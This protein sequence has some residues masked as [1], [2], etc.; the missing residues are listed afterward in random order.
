MEHPAIHYTT[1][2]VKFFLEPGC[3]I[4]VGFKKALLEGDH[5]GHIMETL[6]ARKSLFGD[7]GTFDT[8]L[9]TGEDVDW[10][11]RTRDYGIPM[12]VIPQVLVHKR[13]HDRNLSLNTM[14]NNQNLL[15]VLK[16]S[17]D[18]NRN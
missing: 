17:I 5:V 7:I 3:S 11:C 4:P 16:Q 14:E 13:I 8:T 10:F 9:S 2:K 15:R 6:V 12:A 18:R 1:A